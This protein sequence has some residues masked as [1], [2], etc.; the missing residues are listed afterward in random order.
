MENATEI[1]ET[2]AKNLS[3]RAASFKD[4]VTVMKAMLNDNGYSVDVYKKDGTTTPYCPG[5]EFKKL[6]TNVVS[7]VTHMPK[8]EAGELVN[9]YE[10][11]RS[12]AEIMVGVSKEFI[13]SYLQTGRKLPLG[14]RK[15]SDIELLR[16]VIPTR[17]VSIPCEGPGRASIRVPEH[18][19]I[20]VFQSCPSWIV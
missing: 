9:N 18:G 15:D 6:M 11:S 7:S 4:E 1:I 10:L 2:I 19:G 14:G 13:N 5:Q 12:D 20:K 16:K 8:K 3:Q 17:N